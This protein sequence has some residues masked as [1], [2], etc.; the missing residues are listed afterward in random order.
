MKPLFFLTTVLWVMP[1]SDG[2]D[3]NGG[4]TWLGS[5]IGYLILE[6]FVLADLILDDQVDDVGL[7]SGS[8]S[9][10]RLTVGDAT[11]LPVAVT[12]RDLSRAW[13]WASSKEISLIEE[14]PLSVQPGIAKAGGVGSTALSA[15]LFSGRALMEALL[16]GPL[17]WA[18][19]WSFRCGDGT[20]VDD[21]VELEWACEILDKLFASVNVALDSLGPMEEA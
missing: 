2:S 9:L 12:L 3:G 14:A 20:G 8:P 19:R 18:K 15:A 17:P 16:I 13:A 4:T 11:L 21:T 10:K 6:L 5:L 1:C 7:G